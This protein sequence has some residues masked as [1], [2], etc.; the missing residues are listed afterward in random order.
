MNVVVRSGSR[1]HL[2][3]IDMN[4][5]TSG[6][7]DGGIGFMLNEPAVEVAVSAGSDSLVRW[8][9]ELPAE[10]VEVFAPQVREVLDR[11]AELAGGAAAVEVNSCPPPH[12][13]LGSKTALLLSTAAGAAAVYGKTLDAVALAWVTRRGGTSGVG[14]HGFLHGGLLVDGGHSWADKGFAGAPYRPSSYS[15]AVPVPPLLC[16]M[17]VEWPVL[18]LHPRGRTIH[19]ATEAELFNE[20]CPVPADDVK[21]LS[22]LILM[23]LLPAIAEGDL[24]SFGEALWRI[25]EHRWK[26][27]EIASQAPGIRKLMRRLRGETGMCG[28]AMSS[29]GTAIACFDPRLSAPSAA[30]FAD[31]VRI[32]MEE[33]TGGGSTIMTGVRNLPHAVTSG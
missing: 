14:I 19:G 28:A 25:Q 4:G 17:P 13:G 21:A 23:Q 12:A 9:P 27:F 1:I 10:Y 2:T 16:R 20:V 31:E 26:S 32:L 8:S 29:W 15:A 3:L 7:V 22:H 18:V 11:V 5:Q 6:R 33:E 30:R 24:A